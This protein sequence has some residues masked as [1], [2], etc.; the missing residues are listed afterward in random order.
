VWLD[1]V[2]SFDDARLEEAGMHQLILAGGEDVQT[3]IDVISGR[4]NDLHCDDQSSRVGIGEPRYRRKGRTS[5]QRSC[6]QICEPDSCLVAW[7]P[8]LL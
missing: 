7:M 4:E 6:A 8:P 5:K 1:N 2:G 3:D